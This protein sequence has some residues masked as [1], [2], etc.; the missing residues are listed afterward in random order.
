MTIFPWAVPPFMGT[1]MM[2][3]LTDINGKVLQDIAS[4]QKEWADFVHRRINEDVAVSRQLISCQSLADMHEVYS[5]YLRIAF[6]QYQEQS[7]RAVRRARAARDE[8]VETA[9]ARARD[10]APR[11]RH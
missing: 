1:T 3:L 7:Q 10:A 11:A 4:A 8:L 5:R 2:S 9:E 6:D